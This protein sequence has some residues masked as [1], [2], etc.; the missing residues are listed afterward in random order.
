VTPEDIERIKDRMKAEGLTPRTQQYAIGTFFRIWKHAAKRKLVK[1]GDN[2]AIS[3]QVE[4]VNNTRLRIVTPKELKDILNYLTVNDPAAYAIVMFC[5][6]TGCRF[7]EA[8]ALTYEYVD[9]NRASAI[10]Y[11]TKNKDSREIYFSSEIVALLQRKGNGAT[12]QHVFTKKDGTPYKEPPSAFS[13]AVKRLG[14]NKDRGARDLLTLHSLRHTAA[15]LAAR[16]GVPVKDMQ[17]MFGWKTPSMVFRYAKGN[18]DLQ[19]EAMKGLAHSLS[20]EVGK[21]VPIEEVS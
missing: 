13:T 10:F 12:G 2:P 9:L 15:S 4:R 20:G 17:I 3:V 14:L 11:Q 5:A 19:R 21:I 1:A 8:A 7:S 18:E 16:R 6:Y